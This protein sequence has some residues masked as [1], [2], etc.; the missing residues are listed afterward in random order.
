M[1]NALILPILITF[2]ISGCSTT[3]N[4]KVMTEEVERIR[5][6]L[7]MPPVVVLEQINW[8]IINEGNQEEVFAELT[9][10][11]IDPVLFG[12]TD[13]DYELLQKNNVQLRNQI[14]RYRQIIEA[15]KEYY[16]PKKEETSTKQNKSF[17]TTEFKPK[18]F[19][20]DD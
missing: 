6:D 10:A 16:E 3:K 7:D 2:L 4:L 5:L 19:S 13:E 9:K 1:Q 12:L 11:N 8:K 20:K 18:D 14:I 17:T 15:Y